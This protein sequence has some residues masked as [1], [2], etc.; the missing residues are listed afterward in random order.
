VAGF[1]AATLKGY[2]PFEAAYIGNAVAADCITALGAS[3]AIRRFDVYIKKGG[4][5]E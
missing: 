3:T 4:L 2:D 1:I 5:K